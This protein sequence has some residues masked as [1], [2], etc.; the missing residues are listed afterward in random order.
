MQ[1]D[2]AINMLEQ[3][4]SIDVHL[5]PGDNAARILE[6]ALSFQVDE[7]VRASIV[8]AINVLKSDITQSTLPVGLT[9]NEAGQIFSTSSIEDDYTIRDWL[10]LNYTPAK[11]TQSA[12]SRKFKTSYPNPLRKA[13]SPKRSTA[14]PL[15]QHGRAPIYDADAAELAAIAAAMDGVEEWEW[16]VFK[17]AA[18]SRNR[19]LQ[20]LGWHLLHRWDLIA[21]LGLDADKVPPGS[22]NLARALRPA[23]PTPPPPLVTRLPHQCETLGAESR[24]P[25]SARFAGRPTLSLSFARRERL[26]ARGAAGLSELFSGPANEGR[27]ATEDALD[28]CL[29][30]HER[31]DGKG[32]PHG[33]A[34]AQIVTLTRMSAVCDVY[35]A[36]TSNRPYKAGWDPAESI[37]RMAS[38]TGH[39]DEQMLAAFVKSI[40]IYPTGSL[41]RMASGRIGV[42]AEQNP[43]KLSSPVVKLFYS[44]KAGMPIPPVSLDLAHAATSDRIVGREPND[45]WGFK[46]F[47]ELWLDPEVRRASR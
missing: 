17:L 1:I 18:A 38:W 14:L 7:Y 28:V 21:A 40:G 31:I 11:G 20:T 37:A 29:H 41:V 4:N 46:Q 15:A 2:D 24:Q 25:L 6:S 16:D 39:F 35:D 22:R 5:S 8:Y 26:P 42:V 44:T 13:V 10:V 9:F 27:G 12:G 43:E 47:D 45:R 19:P 23:S 32:Y 36:I 3:Q 30:H 34:A 33:L